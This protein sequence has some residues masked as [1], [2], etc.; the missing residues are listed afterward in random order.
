MRMIVLLCLLPALAGCNRGGG[1]RAAAPN[2]P[3]LEV[4]G[5]LQVADSP[6]RIIYTPPVDLAKRPRRPV[7]P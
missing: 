6:Y 2:G 4:V 5:T 3:P 1:G 7:G